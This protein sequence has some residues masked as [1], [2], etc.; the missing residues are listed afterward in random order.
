MLLF[1]LGSSHVAAEQ[2]VTWLEGENALGTMSLLKRQFLVGTD[3]TRVHA[4][5]LEEGYLPMFGAA[6]LLSTASYSSPAVRSPVCL[7]LCRVL[8]HA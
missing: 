2:I 3:T 6:Q 8:V 5:E 4:K 7:S 1:P